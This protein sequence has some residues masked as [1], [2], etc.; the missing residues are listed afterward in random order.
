MAHP[1][2]PIKRTVPPSD[3]DPSLNGR[4]PTSSLTSVAGG[5]FLHRKVAAGWNAFV[6]A[7][8]AAGFT[9]TYTPGGTYRTYATQYATFMQRYSKPFDERIH[10][11][12]HSRTFQGERWY[13]K[14]GMAPAA[15][16]G[17]S[18]HGNACA[19]DVALDGYG[20]K[21]RSVT[22]QWT[23]WA[24]GVARDYGFAWSLQVE[25]WH[26]QW[27]MGDEL[28]SALTPPPLPPPLNIPRENEMA[29]IGYFDAEPQYL[30]V[31]SATGWRGLNPS[32]IIE[33]EYV[34][35]ASRKPDGSLHAIPQ[36]W[37]SKIPRTG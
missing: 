7:G 37:K 16:P 11:V 3:V 5:G 27:V 12:N 8:A 36:T 20:T 26:I 15:A 35:L 9:M 14:K 21:A 28:P 25:P 31:L 1:T 24:V 13:L 32:D 33:L 10:Q 30:V 29:I 18:P 34:G 17:T 4:I 22:Y 23:N 2:F 19:I 6:A